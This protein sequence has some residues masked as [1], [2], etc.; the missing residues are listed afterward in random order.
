M[1]PAA[2]PADSR[3]P[4]SQIHRATKPRV[5]KNDP[6]VA[7]KQNAVKGRAREGKLVKKGRTT[8]VGDDQPPDAKH[9]SSYFGYFMQTVRSSF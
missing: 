5:A 4:L 3:A 9:S 7:R 6:Y 2:D 1:D 8:E